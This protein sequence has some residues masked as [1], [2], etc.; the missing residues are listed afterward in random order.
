MA[1][2]MEKVNAQ[3]KREISSMLQADFHDSRFMFVTVT[4]VVVSP[5]LHQARVNFTVL[6]DEGQVERVTED[7]NRVRGFIRKLV[8]E[9]VRLRYTPEIE[10]F[11]DKSVEYSDRIE[12][13]LQEIHALE[14]ERQ[15]KPEAVAKPRQARKKS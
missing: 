9:R 10:F 1:L 15:T 11:Y 3:M 13:T 12:R 5:D 6:G 8:G 7:L 2:R 14:A 4:K